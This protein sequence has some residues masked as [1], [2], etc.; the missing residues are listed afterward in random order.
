MQ[1]RD[2]AKAAELEEI[3][4]KCSAGKPEVEDASAHNGWAKKPKKKKQPRMCYS[5]G[6][7]GGDANRQSAP[8]KNV[9][10]TGR[11]NFTEPTEDEV[12]GAEPTP[13]EQEAPFSGG[14]KEFSMTGLKMTTWD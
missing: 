4:R 9:S 1:A 5:G 6:A 10:S 13:V 8:Q 11:V 12:P 2:A 7:G 3:L 14:T